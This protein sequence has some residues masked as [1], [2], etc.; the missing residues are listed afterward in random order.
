MCHFCVPI[1]KGWYASN[2][3]LSSALILAIISVNYVRSVVIHNGKISSRRK[4][5]KRTIQLVNRYAISVLRSFPHIL[6]AN[7]PRK[8]ETQP[9]HSMVEAS[10]IPVK[11]W[12]ENS[13]PMNDLLYHF[14]KSSSSPELADSC[15]VF[16]MNMLSRLTN[17][18]YIC[19]WVQAF[20]WE[21]RMAL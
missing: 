20:I 11:L 8:R 4:Y 21:L 5:C 10:N 16:L 12:S 7:A 18:R 3:D 9:R 1:P 2:T 19:S 6:P 13:P 17:S 15:S 14:E